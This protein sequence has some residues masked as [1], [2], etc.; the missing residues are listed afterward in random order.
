M[1]QQHIHCSVN[2]CHYWKNGNICDANE[3]VVVSDRFG[4]EQP[5]NVDANMVGKFSPTPVDK[6]MDTCCKTFVTEGS[7]KIG[8]DGVKLL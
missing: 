2:N 8:V 5:D 1:N 4:A 6:C 7:G 3:I